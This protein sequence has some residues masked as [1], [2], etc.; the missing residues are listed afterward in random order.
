MVQCATESSHENVWLPL[1]KLI[2]FQFSVYAVGAG[3]SFLIP[4]KTFGMK[5]TNVLHFQKVLSPIQ[6]ILIVVLY[7]FDSIKLH[8]CMVSKMQYTVNLILMI[9]QRY[10]D[11]SLGWKL[12]ALPQY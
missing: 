12:L 5:S 7:V 8:F 11:I 6:S 9:P 3:L 2:A 1:S 4:N 10:E